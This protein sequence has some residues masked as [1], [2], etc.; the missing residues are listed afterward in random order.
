VTHGPIQMLVP[1]D[2]HSTQPWG[3]RAAAPGKATGRESSRSDGSV[4]EVPSKQG[5]ILNQG[6]A[7]EILSGGGGGYGDPLER[8]LERIRDDLVDRR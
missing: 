5:F 4:A 7:L 6:D 1:L 2:R 3:S 8:S